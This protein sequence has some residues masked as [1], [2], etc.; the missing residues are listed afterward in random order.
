MQDSYTTLLKS[1][2]LEQLFTRHTQLKSQISSIY[3]ATL[4][5]SQK[6]QDDEVRRRKRASRGRGRG[7][8]RSRGNTHDNP[9]PWTRERGIKDAMRQ[10]RRVRGLEG[11]QGEGL[12]EFSV[13]V[14]KIYEESTPSI[15]ERNTMAELLALDFRTDTSKSNA[16]Y[17][18]TN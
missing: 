15:Q 5:P 13:F 9:A 1:N 2:D 11:Q 6:D 8:G 17:D 3:T 12:R 10:L 14:T 7:R 4:E 18:S 16:L